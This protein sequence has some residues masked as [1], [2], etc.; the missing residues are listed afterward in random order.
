MFCSVE[1]MFWTMDKEFIYNYMKPIWALSCARWI[2]AEFDGSVVLSSLYHWLLNS[3][4]MNFIHC[5]ACRVYAGRLLSYYPEAHRELAN[6]QHWFRAAMLQSKFLHPEGVILDVISSC[7]LPQHVPGTSAKRSG[8]PAPFPS[9]RFWQEMHRSQ[10]EKE[11]SIDAS[12]VKI[13]VEFL[14]L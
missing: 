13:G 6:T 14:M 7:N 8:F 11:L 1:L 9:C 2:I 4:W 3:T 5:R 12:L 10:V